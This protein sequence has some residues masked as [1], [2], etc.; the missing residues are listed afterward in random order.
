M[1]SHASPL[2]LVLF[3]VT[4][5]TS[6]LLLF[7]IQPMIGKAILPRFGGTASVWAT[8]M[9]FFQAVLLAGYAYAHHLTNRL[10][11]GRQAVI[12][13]VL[14]VLPLVAFVVFPI[15]W[16]DGPDIEPSMH[17]ALGTLMLLLVLV[18]LPAFVVCTSAPLLQR[19][20]ANTGHPAARDPYFLYAASNLGSMVSLLSY[21]VLVEPQL[22]LPHQGTLWMVGYLLLLV[23]T[24]SCAWLVGRA[25]PETT[26]APAA[27]A[28]ADDETTS[29]PDETPRSDAI[30]AKPRWE[31]APEPAEPAG[32]P[33]AAQ[34]LRWL[35]LAFVPSSLVLGVTTH[36]TTDIAAVPLIWLAPLT[37]YLLSFIIVFSQNTAFFQRW[38]V[39]ALPVLVLILA[40]LALSETDVWI[41]W[42][43]LIHL[44]TLLAAA[45]ICHGA[46]AHD[47]PSTEHL[48]RFYLCMSVGGVLGGL[49][50][51]LLAP[52]VFNDV[53]EYYLVLV[54]ACLCLPRQE[55]DG[56]SPAAQA[57]D[58]AMAAALG[59]GAL[60]A[61]VKF[62]S[63][64]R[65]GD[66][67]LERLR[68]V[69]NVPMVKFAGWTLSLSVPAIALAY[70]LRGPRAQWT[71]RLLDVLVP[72]ALGLIALRFLT[73]SPLEGVSMAWFQNI[74]PAKDYR[75]IAVI[76]GTVLV[77]IAYVYAGQPLRFAL[78]VGVLFLVTTP[79]VDR[80]VVLYKERNFFGVSKVEAVKENGQVTHHRLYHGTTMHGQQ[81][82][83]GDP[84][85]LSVWLSMLAA[86]GGLSAV[87]QTALAQDT[88]RDVRN[89]PIAYFHQN[90][91]VG[92]LFGA[93][94]HANADRRPIG[95]IGLGT[96][97]LCG[98]VLHGQPITFYDIDPLM[99]AIASN[100]DYF[101]FLKD[102]RGKPEIVMGDGRLRLGQAPDGKYRMIIMDAFSS[103][104]IPIHLL[105]R[106]AVKMYFDKLTPDGALVVH[107]SNRY[108]KLAPVLG[109]I[110]EDLGLT[111]VA[112]HDAPDDD[113]REKLASHWVVLA[114]KPEDLGPLGNA[115]QP[116][117][118]A[119]AADA[120]LALIGSPISLPGVNARYRD[121]HWIPPN[122]KKS[123][124]TDKYSNLL[125]TLVD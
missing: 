27:E 82:R 105:T 73:Q 36:F 44:G 107:I 79:V 53:S 99:V 16:S 57:F 92:Q 104:A 120:L 3:A 69:V 85:V 9:V 10:S 43:F 89:Q 97:T 47:R 95:V 48:T 6:A 76:S 56:K 71:T 75:L 90:G 112:M 125:S 108:L 119:I 100:P 62:V 39:E 34:Q 113:S 86:D 40:F 50:N 103:D 118:N 88:A 52:V 83:D 31:K 13:S 17:P 19:W 20:F 102:C 67:D 1:K 70:V 124:W 18:G 78:C 122:A 117:D 58:F 98:Y 96:G 101:T 87:A 123:L 61:C 35:F 81:R 28:P 68:Q 91:P 51:A 41:G 21:P 110:A 55:E 93:L 14:L 33:T 121:W 22:G 114:R 109:N 2:P 66:D 115:G 46:L 11:V 26:A 23:L 5:F 74:V 59:L 106:E 30:T 42:L 72:A 63:D 24:L 37:L 4:L 77:A 116:S 29:A 45:V 7:L 84:R 38:M 12:H 80:G 94:I 49:F 54:L 25:S 60:W 65:V 111:A 8:C 64:W 32:P 15:G